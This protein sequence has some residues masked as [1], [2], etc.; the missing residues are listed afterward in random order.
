MLNH[1]SIGSLLIGLTIVLFFSLII[2]KIN[3]DREGAFLCQ[4]V[5]ASPKLTMEEC[6]AHDS[7]SSWLLLGA[8]AISFL[9]LGAGTYMVLLP[10]KKEQHDEPVRHIDTSKLTEEELKLYDLIKLNQGSKYQSDLIQET[11]M[12]KVKISR[13]LDRMEGK[14]IVERKRRGMT[15]I[16]IL[17]S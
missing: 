9:I 10:V 5:E 14:S 7:N 11:G 1:K 8:F 15:N 16:I 2:I 3:T 4:L 6:P 17:K 13:I 12:S